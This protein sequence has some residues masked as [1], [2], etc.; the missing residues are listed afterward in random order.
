MIGY[1][2]PIKFTTSDKRILTFD[3]FKREASARSEKHAP[4]GRKP[5]KEFIG[6]ELD[7]ITFTILFSAANGVNPRVDMEKWLRMC[8]TGEAHV[9]VIG[10]RA[11]GLDKWT[12][13]SVSQSWDVIFN[14]GE[15]YSSK[16]DITLEEYIEVM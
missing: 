14:K 1:Y 11:L 8:R 5:V 9:L 2:G 16:V 4:I 12:V 10:K 15:L 6:P 3:D 7:T 13:E